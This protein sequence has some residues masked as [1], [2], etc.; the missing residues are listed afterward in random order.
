MALLVVG[1]SRGRWPQ[2][3]VG[4]RRSE[5]PVKNFA[6]YTTPGVWPSQNRALVGAHEYPCAPS[7]GPVVGLQWIELAVAP[8]SHTSPYDFAASSM[9]H[10][11][12]H[13]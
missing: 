8:S 1:D 3:K 5:A 10:Q 7:H 9:M 13:E 2:Y 6:L 4:S 11:G 12:A